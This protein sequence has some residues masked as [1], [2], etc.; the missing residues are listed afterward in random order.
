MTQP[1]SPFVK[2]LGVI[3]ALAGIVIFLL[4]TEAGGLRKLDYI[5]AAVCHRRPSHSFEIADQQLPLCQRCTG[6]FPGALIGVLV[7]WGLW[8]RRRS[9]AF[10]RWPILVLALAFAALWGLDGINSTT[11][12]SQFYLL[13]QPLIE[14]PYG[15][16][17]LGYAP[18]PWLRLLTG[19][20]MGMSMSIILVP[21]FNQSLWGDGEET[22]TLRSGHELATLIA[23][24][25]AMAV[26]VLLLEATQSA[27]GLYA[28]AITSTLGVLVMFTLLGAMLFVLLLQRDGSMHSW[29]QAWIPLVWGLAFALLLVGVMDGTR[30]WMNGTIDGVPGLE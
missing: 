21:A 11:S 6:T 25:I 3:L 12:D 19:A 13:T 9:L 1:F 15:V 7:H 20:L 18:Q 2:W 27:V 26:A 23:I 17:I 29:S 10:P 30:L 4:L 8:R 28:V 24:E 22:A 16:G 14:R 5:G